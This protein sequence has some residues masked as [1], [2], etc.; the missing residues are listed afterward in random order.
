MQINVIGLGYTGLPLALWL[1]QK[2]YSVLGIDTDSQLI[3]KI[4][5]GQ[6]DLIEAV[7][8]SQQNFTQFLQ[9]QLTQADFSVTTEYRRLSPN[10]QVHLLTV[11]I[12]VSQNGQYNLT[13]LTEAITDLARIL[14]PDDL[15]IIK[16][17]LIPG[18]MT[19]I[20]TPLLEQHGF[21]PGENLVLAYCP[22]RLAEGTALL[23][24]DK[25]PRLVAAEDNFSLDQALD[26]WLAVSTAPVV[27]IH[28]FLIAEL[29]K[30]IENI[31]RDVNIAL[32]NE[33]NRLLR[34]LDC[35]FSDLQQAANTHPRV[36]L[37]APGP[38]VGGHCLPNAL[39]YLEPVAQKYGINLELLKTARDTNLNRPNEIATFLTGICPINT[40]LQ[41]KIA[42]LGLGMKNH[43]ADTRLS[44][45]LALADLLTKVGYSVSL[46]DPLVPQLSAPTLDAALNNFQVAI[47]T[48]LQPGL[49]ADAILQGVQACSPRPII[50]DTKQ[51]INQTQAATLGVEVHY[52]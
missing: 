2:G 1:A 45:A 31:C 8:N 28:S 16:G 47:I 23:D 19:T 24:L 49:S 38:G 34:A 46:F 26:F 37:L 43:C 6:T 25:V 3:Q 30:V 15:V 51:V 7:P 22:E 50:I 39:W 21:R 11:G 27:P 10:Q 42:I 52:A 12:P 40:S 13:P 18:S 44:P 17:T 20:V 48:A 32:S 41:P 29:S 9:D 35:T 5:K 36:Q 14:I 4:T 33:L